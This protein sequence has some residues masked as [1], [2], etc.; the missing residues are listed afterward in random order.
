M[1][2]MRRVR[3]CLLAALAALFFSCEQAAGPAVPEKGTPQ[4]QEE[5]G[6]AVGYGV[7]ANGVNGEEASTALLFTFDEDVTGLR[8]DH[9]SL[10]S[11]EGAT[12]GSVAPGDL[13][14]EGK[15]WSLG[16]AAQKA[17][18]LWVKINKTGIEGG[19]KIVTVFRAGERALIGYQAA[20]D[21]GSRK[22]STAIAFTFGAALPG[23]TAENITISGE[24]SVTKRSLSGSGQNWSLAITVKTPGEIRV[25]I[26]GADIET[27]KKTLTVHKPVSWSAAADGVAGS[28][29]STKIDFTFAAEVSG[30]TTGEISIVPADRVTVGALAGGG[31]AWTL[32]IAALKA[33]EIR[34]NIHKD[35]VE[36]GEQ[37]VSV[38]H[39]KPVGYTAAANGVNGKTNSTAIVFS[40]DEDISGLSADDISLAD[41][42]G[43]ALKGELAGSGKQW[44][45]G[46]TVQ[47]AGSVK[48]AIHK[49]GVE[50]GERI[51]DVYRE[52]EYILASYTA[53]ADG[54]VRTA[55]TAISF[56]FGAAI[57]GLAAKDITISGEG[58]VTNG[59]LSGSG[60]NWSLA[61]A[62]ESP[63]TLRVRINKDG[64]EAG[65]QTVT[66]YKPV[67]YEAAA[68]SAGGTEATTRID[69]IFSEAVD[70]LSLWNVSYADDTGSAY[71]LDFT[72]SGEKWSL[73]IIVEKTG[74]IRVGIDKDGIESGEKIVYVYK[75]EEIPPPVPEK[76]GITV[77]TPPDIVIYAKNQ[78]FDRTGLEVGWVYSDG[79]IEPI[80]AGGYHLEEP[81]MSVAVNKRVSIQAGDYKTSF[82]I[83]VLNTDKILSHIT[84]TGPTN[85]VQDLGREF[86]RT[87]LEVTGHYSDGSTSNLTSLIAIAGYDK[88][89]RGPQAVSVRVNGKSAALEGIVIRIGDEAAVLVNYPNTTANKNHQALD[90][91]GAWIKG[92]AFSPRRANLIFEVY[93]PKED[94]YGT[95]SFA[96][97]Y[98]NGGLTDQDFATLTGYNP[99]QT[100]AQNLSMTVDGR[101]LNLKVYVMDMEPSVWF[102]YGYMRHAGDPTGHG[103]GEGKYYAKPNETLII[104]PVRYLVGYNEDAGDAGVSYTWTVSGDDSSR[105][106]N[107]SGGGELLNITPRTAGTYTITV[108][109]KGRNFVT[110]SMDTKSASAELVCYTSPLPAGT[111]VSPLK[112]F[113]AGQMSAGGTGYGWSLGSAGGYEVWTVEHQ[114][115]YAIEGN[116]FSAWHEAGVVWMQEDRN[117]NGLPDEMW[118]ELRGGD[119][120]N[121]A[122]K[123]YITRR[124]AV[125]YFKGSDYGTI[126]E[127]G[128]YI[129]EVYWGDSRGRSGMIPGGFPY[130]WGVVGDRVT[131]T[132][133]LLRDNGQIGTGSYTDLVPMPGYVD[134]LGIDF[135]V[136]K[137]MRADGTPVTLTAVK[138]IKVQ[139]GVFRYGGL[140]GDVSTEIQSADFLGYQSWFPK[141]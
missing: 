34:V 116:A 110:G 92:E 27:G 140:Y 113:G 89:K 72:G 68:D 73:L 125:T 91:R 63:G 37:T 59:E 13:S 95:N 39:Y 3:V 24:G 101:K 130:K 132:C 100:G 133:T 40:F 42:T 44:S 139:T 45:L 50:A 26:A 57:P 29:S 48:A 81:D 136:N 61:I 105:T 1:R 134:A 12:G 109:V 124:Y 21:G 47:Q 93:Y 56:T 5:A 83:Q 121:A 66:V 75:P 85:K 23:L 32:G 51:V 112:N 19:E 141:P 127:Y 33:G 2:A 74:D 96:L 94:P 108:D 65:E 10:V 123:N 78:T 70:G 135:Y 115:S 84:V 76:T 106:W 67:S 28:A 88:N 9:I 15:T 122:W 31:T 103:P 7:A 41:G 90:Y 120:D 82:W 4:E 60:Q 119:D 77:I 126:N 16:I 17:G 43:G 6:K 22:A 98:E 62:V 46:I 114:P 25:G 18:N 49:A 79:S 97:T 129:S 54:N 55:S 64:I 53:A 52:G 14:G 137:A 71:P 104:A 107:T 117:G 118:Y 131:Y 8:A 138:F 30:L 38:Y 111:F 102:D 86:D 20:A 36:E 58:S 69:F 99:W 35:G 11:V 80:P 128:Q 87:G